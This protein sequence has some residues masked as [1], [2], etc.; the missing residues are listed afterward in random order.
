MVLDNTNLPIAGVSMRIEG[1]TMMTQT[2]A[3][4]QFIL[5]GAPVGYVKLIADGSTAQRPGTWPMLEYAVFTISGQNNTLEMP[6]YL[7]PIDV[8][9]GIQVSE[10]QGGTLTLPEL[11][12]FSLTVDPGSAIF[13]G[14]SRTGTISVTL[15]HADKVPMAPGFGQQP[16]FIVTIQPTGVLLVKPAPITYPNVDGLAPGEVTEL[17][18]FDHDLGQFVSIGTGSV[19]EDGL[20]VRSDP[21]V[22]IIKSG[23]NCEGPPAPAGTA[24][25]CPECQRCDGAICAPDASLERAPCTSDSSPCTEDI[26]VGGTCGHVPMQVEFGDNFYV[27]HDDATA[28]ATDSLLSGVAVYANDRAGDDVTWRISVTSL[29]ARPVNYVWRVVGP[30][31]RTGPSGV[32][33]TAWTVSRINWKPGFYNIVCEV[34]FDNGCRISRTW[35]QQVGVRTNDYI[36]VGTILGEPL[37]TAGVLPDTLSRFSCPAFCRINP[38]DIPECPGRNALIDA[39]FNDPASESFVPE[40]LADRLYVSYFGFQATSNTFPVPLALSQVRRFISTDTIAFGLDPLSNYRQ[41]VHVQFK[42][43]VR[44]GR[45]IGVPFYVGDV[46]SIDGQTPEPCK[47]RGGIYGVPGPMNARLELYPDQSGFSYSMQFRASAEAQASFALLN[48]RE[49]PYVFFRFRFDA[50]GG[51]LKS[52]ISLGPSITEDGADGK[53]YSSVPTFFLYRRSSYEGVYASELQ[54]GFPLRENLYNFLLI[55]RPIGSPTYP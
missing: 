5:S 13:P 24:A 55:A 3:Q 39:R 1:T 19:S 35:G 48:R 53:D 30:E 2:D 25:S 33:A 45:I 41:V 20:I 32:T 17:Y 42:Y 4:G 54:A 40:R 29:R 12:G 16:K 49:L 28:T 51:E 11:P 31:N 44:D 6:V 26:C 37:P 18:S 7:L 8:R 34:T 21:G 15:V 23:W 27:D 38:F 50:T 46:F 10:T 22:G 14:G 52:R 43:L 36:L 47:K 9:R